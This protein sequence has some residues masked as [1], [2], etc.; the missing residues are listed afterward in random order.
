MN[1]T[2]ERRWILMVRTRLISSIESEIV[3]LE[4]TEM[5]DSGSDDNALRERASD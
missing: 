3:K 5:H 4:V 1:T 2:Q